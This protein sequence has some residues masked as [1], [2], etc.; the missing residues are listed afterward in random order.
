[1]Y[2]NVNGM[3]NAYG[4]YTGGY[5]SNQYNRL[6]AMEQQQALAQQAI[7]QQAYGL[8]GAQPA[9]PNGTFPYMQST[10]SNFLKGRPVTGIEE[11]RASQIDLDG[12]PFIFPDFSHQKIY[13]KQIGL[14]GSA[15]LK[16][17]TLI[18]D[19]APQNTTQNI[20]QVSPEQTYITRHELEEV[21]AKFR[22]EMLERSTLI[23][24]QQ[25]QQL[26]PPTNVNEP[27]RKQSSF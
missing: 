2:N 19:T 10:A 9:I 11:A 7:N 26:Q 12:S 13:T 15:S 27:V 24:E 16:T 1:M 22:Q 20:Q 21:M 18:D 17:Y 5:N 3:P 25:Q 14:D 6:A 8:Q 4:Q 23:G